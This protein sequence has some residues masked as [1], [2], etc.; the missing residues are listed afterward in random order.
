M[1]KKYLTILVFVMT[2]S[3]KSA[4]TTSQN[5]NAQFDLLVHK[6]PTC[7]CCKSGLITWKKM[8]FL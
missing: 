2:L 8:D 3:L 7:G 5:I 4:V 6:T 1:Y